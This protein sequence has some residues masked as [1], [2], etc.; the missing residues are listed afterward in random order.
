MLFTWLDLQ[1]SGSDETTHCRFSNALV[2]AHAHDALLAEVCRQ[3]EHHGL[4]AKEAAAA[5]I[6][7][8]LIESSPS[9]YSCRGAR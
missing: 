8:T 4:R 7:S 1:G 9:T 3:I 6:D 2:K 5:I